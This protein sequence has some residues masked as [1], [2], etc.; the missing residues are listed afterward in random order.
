VD[1][2]RTL[3]LAA[4][5]LLLAAAP[6]WAGPEVDQAASALREDPVY[7]DAEADPD[8][9]AAEERRLELDIGAGDAGPVYV[10]VLPESAREE[11]AGNDPDRLPQ[12]LYDALRERGTYAVV[13]GT[14]LS[15][16]STDLPAGEI[17]AQAARE[18]R[19][20]G[21]P[22]VLAGFVDGVAAERGGGNGS[23][24]SGGDGEGG[25]SGGL[26]L[27]GLLAAGG[28]LF[29]V[30][31]A[32]RR[33]R[34]AAE[35]AAQMEDLRREAR[36]D[37]VALGD[38]VRAIDVDVEMPGVDPRAH[39]ALALALQR[40]DEAETALDQA[41]RPEDFAPISSAL[42]EARWS[43]EVAKAHLEG[44][45]P[46]ERR[47]PCFFDPRHGPSVRDVEW[48]PPGGETRPVPVC[49]AD[50]VR[51]ES[52]ED[53]HAREVTVN[54]QRMPYYDAPGYFGP[55]AGGYFGGY[56]LGF[57]GF[58]PGLLF[59]SMLG[60]GMFGGGIGDAAGDAGGDFGGGDWGGGGDFGGGF[61]GGGDFG[62]GDFG[63][64][65]GDF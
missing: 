63:G 45:P 43:M 55:W 32:R 9:S 41:R 10:A 22:A 48:V 19:G 2:V 23:S 13:T 34:E 33:R 7:V 47:P 25:G 53:P 49:A 59:G 4:I 62:G 21:L 1:A 52:G 27:L 8:L 39:E 3:A 51:I 14:R 40:Y 42:E 64:G 31:R 30:S 16:G 37:L 18:H 61:G 60:G 50:A 28:G 15:A 35:T 12:L 57:G 5:M 11:A 44:R 29:A 17:A 26:V 58:L 24:G 20:E 6:A 38:D 54:G 56:G 65:G 36:D 46:P